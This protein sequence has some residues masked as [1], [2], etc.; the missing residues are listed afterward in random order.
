MC[1]HH[2]WFYHQGEKVIQ[3][4]G[5]SWMTKLIVELVLVLIEWTWWDVFSLENITGQTQGML[6]KLYLWAG[7]LCIYLTNHYIPNKQSAWMTHIFWLASQSIICSGS[8]WFIDWFFL[9]FICKSTYGNDESYSNTVN[10]WL[11]GVWKLINLWVYRWVCSQ[12]CH[13]LLFYFCFDLPIHF[14]LFIK[15][16]FREA[17]AYPCTSCRANKKSGWWLKE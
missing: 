17:E 11:F 9:W 6:D 5:P 3:T 13:F 15:F 12:W 10:S 8:L 14:L 4:R 7:C 1:W 2:F 16:W